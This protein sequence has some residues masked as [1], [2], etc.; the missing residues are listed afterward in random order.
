MQKHSLNI[1]M[2]SKA[3][4]TTANY[5]LWCPQAV[6]TYWS[7]GSLA[8]LIADFKA[9][10]EVD[11]MHQK[12]KESKLAPAKEAARPRSS[13][14]LA[15]KEHPTFDI[16]PLLA[17]SFLSR[18]QTWKG[19]E[20]ISEQKE[21]FQEKEKHEAVNFQQP[22]EIYTPWKDLEEEEVQPEL[23]QERPSTWAEA[24]RRKQYLAN[25]TVGNAQEPKGSSNHATIVQTYLMY[26]DR[27]CKTKTRC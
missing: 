13:G 3:G 21:F 7:I 8:L 17:K 27:S 4:Y 24:L 26:P 14:K 2:P 18:L 19:E 1:S 15:K 5:A 9:F 20:G 12:S 22:S 23:V 10:E 6:S 11:Q 16:S 25:G